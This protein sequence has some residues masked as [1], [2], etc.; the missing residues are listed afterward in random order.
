MS[1][2]GRNDR[3][4]FLCH[5]AQDKD[6]VRA[7]YAR[8]RA[9][10][11]NPWLDEENLVAGQNFDIEIHK[12]I[13]HSA[14]FL[15]FLS[16]HAVTKRGYLQK[17]IRRALAVADEMPEGAIFLIPVRLEECD[18]PERLS[19][20]HWVD[21]FRPEGY[22]RLLR[23]VRASS[24][25]EPSAPPR[26]PGPDP[27]TPF[28]PS[29]S[30]LDRLLRERI[31][32]I[33]QQIDAGLAN[34]ICAQLLRLDAEDSSKDITLYINSPG[35][36][37]ADGMAIHDT[38]QYV[39]CDVA[40]IAIG[41]AAGMSQVLLAT[42]AKGKRYALPHSRIMMCAPTAGTGGSNSDIAVQADLFRRHRQEMATLIADHTG[43][44]AERIKI[45]WEPERWF[46]AEEAR[47]YGIVDQILRVPPHGFGQ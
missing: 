39:E 19:H 41:L 35:G 11:L 15:V 42:G 25:D 40:P 46:T 23:A 12:A 30:A 32:V 47:A 6:A 37:V 28:N 8:L 1:G 16:T 33:G 45:D 43:Q 18:V 4:I 3:W 5:S 20:L 34:D 44:A 29:D 9:D 17:E 27:R 38:M 7:I 22:P 2:G 31:I 13:R 21:L 10:G 24:E 26:P 14:A 36:S